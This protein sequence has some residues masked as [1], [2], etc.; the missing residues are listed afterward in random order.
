MVAFFDNLPTHLYILSQDQKSC[1][2]LW[3]KSAFAQGAPPEQVP[4]VGNPRF[5]PV[6]IALCYVTLC[7]NNI[8]GLVHG[9]VDV[10]DLHQQPTDRQN[11]QTQTNAKFQPK[12]H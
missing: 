5:K 2:V 7:I 8:H 11:T 9:N 3:H 1:V 12:A 6:S 4:F 10:I